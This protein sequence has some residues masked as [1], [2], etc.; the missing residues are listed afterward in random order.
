LSAGLLI[1]VVDM[2]AGWLPLRQQLIQSKLNHWNTSLVDSF[3]SE[4]AKRYKKVIRISTSN[5]DHNWETFAYFAARNQL[6]TSSIFLSRIDNQKLDQFNLRLAQ[7]VKLGQYD[8]DTLYILE[9]NQVISA[10]KSINSSKDLLARID[11]FNIIAPG[12]VSCVEC[13]PIAK[14]SW[15]ESLVPRYQVGELI[16]I[17][18]S[19]KN[20]HPFVLLSGWAYPEAW[21]TWSDGRSANLAFTVPQGRPKSLTLDV[22]AFVGPSHPSQNIEIWVDR[23]LYQKQTLIKDQHNLITVPIEDY[24]IKQGYITIDFNFLNPAKPKDLGPSDDDRMLSI[25]LETAIFR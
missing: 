17:S 21:G 10:L 1:Q 25:A 4:A 14:E 7:Q 20:I 19:G 8:A 24:Q 6:A 11:G 5:H 18:R 3:W 12:W 23:K 15:I 13:K 9:N 22:R 16:S 2:S